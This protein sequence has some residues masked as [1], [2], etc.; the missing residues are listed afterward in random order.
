MPAPWVAAEPYYSMYERARIPLAENRRAVEPVDRST[1]AWRF[2]QLLGEEGFREYLGVYYGM[3]SM[4][5]WN[6]G[7]VLEALRRLGAERDTLVIFTS[8]HGDMQGG[9]GMYGKTNYSIYEET[10][11]VPLVMRFPGRM[12]AGKLVGT[13]AG[14]CDLQPTILDYLGIAAPAGIHGR[15]LRPFIDGREDLERPI[16]CE[17]ERGKQ[18]F[19]RM[20][21]TL[22]W[23]YV[24]CSSGESQL[25]HLEKDPGET[26]NLIGEAAARDVKRKLHGDLSAWMKQ[27]GDA[28]AAVLPA[29]V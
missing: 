7:R 21:R 4:V 1:A 15:S 22:A 25:Y 6:V 28:R 14:S 17:R 9:H 29:A 10:T 27:T 13:Q 8:D 12:P 19:Q 20:I 16:F 2:G 23:K 18:H 24:Y 11:R 5:D 26:R 3:V